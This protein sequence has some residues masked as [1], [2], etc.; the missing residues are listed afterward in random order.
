MEIMTR[1][2]ILHDTPMIKAKNKEMA[3]HICENM[4]RKGCPIGIRIQATPERPCYGMSW[5][6]DPAMLSRYNFE[7]N[8]SEQVVQLMESALCKPNLDNY[9]L[10]KHDTRRSEMIRRKEEVMKLLKPNLLEKLQNFINNFL[11]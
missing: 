2:V 10:K 9:N 11:K 5:N 7:E 6:G 1:L 8:T 4:C 3:T